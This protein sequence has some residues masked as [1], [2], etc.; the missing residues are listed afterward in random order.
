MKQ[1]SMVLTGS[2]EPSV[3]GLPVVLDIDS[4]VSNEEEVLHI[5]RISATTFFREISG[6]KTREVAVDEPLN[7]HFSPKHNPSN[8][9]VAL[10]VHTIETAASILGARARLKKTVQDITNGFETGPD[11]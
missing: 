11:V 9:E 3:R 1:V 2:Y 6:P 5:T 7:I 8:A 4:Y 10:V